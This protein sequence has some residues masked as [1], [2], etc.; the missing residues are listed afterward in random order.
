MSPCGSSYMFNRILLA[1]PRY[2]KSPLAH[3][4]PS[5]ESPSKRNVAVDALR[6]RLG[7]P[8]GLQKTCRRPSGVL[9]AAKRLQGP[10]KEVKSKNEQPSNDFACFLY[11]GGSKIDQKSI[12]GEGAFASQLNSTPLNSTLLYFYSTVLYSTLLYLS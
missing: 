6:G 2:R 12:Q 8:R 10:T 7:G 4:S 9:L 5:A 3:I 1:R 11:P